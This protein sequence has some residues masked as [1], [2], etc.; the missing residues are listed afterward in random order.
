MCR[1]GQCV[2]INKP[3]TRG[4]RKARMGVRL[5]DSTL[6][7][8]EPSTWGSEQQPSNRFEGNMVSTQREVDSIYKDR[9]NNHGNRT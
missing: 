6:S 2:S 9:C 1:T 3:R 5:L 8:G 7:L 4:D